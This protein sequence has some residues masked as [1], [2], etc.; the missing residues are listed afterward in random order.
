MERFDQI[1]LLHIKPDKRLE[2]EI[3]YGTFM[4]MLLFYV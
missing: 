2:R 4:K 1:A 3:E